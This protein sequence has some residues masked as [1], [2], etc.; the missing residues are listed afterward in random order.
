LK[1]TINDFRVMVP[2]ESLV[3]RTQCSYCGNFAKRI[4]GK[5]DGISTIKLVEC[6]KCSL[7]STDFFPTNQFLDNYYKK[8]FP[9]Y[10]EKYNPTEKSMVTF[11]KPHRFASRLKSLIPSKFFN[12]NLVRILDFGGAD[13]TLA[14]EFANL[15]SN[16][17]Q[18]EITV[19]DFGQ[20]LSK[21]TKSNIS[22]KKYR[23]SQNM[24]NMI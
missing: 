4:V 12:L 1:A 15:L 17:T 10:V 18:I 9:E 11:S 20:S 16:T 8:K 23:P 6:L 14:L 5:V 19:V 13:G 2:R 24:K 22:I 3:Q 7:V 21:S